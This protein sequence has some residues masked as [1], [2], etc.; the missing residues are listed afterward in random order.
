LIAR[1]PQPPASPPPPS[2]QELMVQLSLIHNGYVSECVWSRPKMSAHVLFMLSEEAIAAGLAIFA[3]NHLASNRLCFGSPCSVL[4]PGNGL[5][6]HLV[7][8]VSIA[9]SGCDTL[10]P[11]ESTGRLVRGPSAAAP[12]GLAAPAPVCLTSRRA[13]LSFSWADARDCA[14]RRLLHVVRS[15]VFSLAHVR[16]ATSAALCSHNRGFQSPPG[17]MRGAYITTI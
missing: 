1:T 7:M 8:R 17:Y 12:P 13:V 3:V 11:D 16:R 15:G 2:L 10:H 4:P 9:S 14:P 6:P 5:L